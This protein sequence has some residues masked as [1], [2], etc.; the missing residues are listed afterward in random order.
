LVFD[1]FA[2]LGEPRTGGVED[3]RFVRLGGIVVKLASEKCV[4][5]AKCGLFVFKEDRNALNGNLCMRD[6]NSDMWKGAKVGERK[7]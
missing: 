6:P 2:L 7:D 3:S 5:L 1:V 4:A